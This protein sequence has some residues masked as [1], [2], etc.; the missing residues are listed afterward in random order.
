MAKA[1]ASQTKA[2]RGKT[3]NVQASLH[4]RGKR[5][6]PLPGIEVVLYDDDLEVQDRQHTTTQKTCSFKQLGSEIYWLEFRD[7]EETALSEV[8]S[9]FGAARVGPAYCAATMAAGM[10]PA[11]FKNLR[12]VPCRPSE[13]DGVS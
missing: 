13:L 8:F 7:G 4:W 10:A 2:R 9:G 6:G 3:I 12:R 5:V 11:C 1:K